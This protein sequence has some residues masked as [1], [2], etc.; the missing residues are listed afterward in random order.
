VA[1]HF[2]ERFGFEVY[3]PRIRRYQTRYRRRIKV[4]RPLFPGYCFTRIELQWHSV[5]QC[6]GVIRIVKGG[7]EEPAHVPDE[8]IDVIRSRERDGALDLP[9]P[10]RPRA[11]R[12]GDRV[13]IVSGLFAGVRAFA[14]TYRTGT[15]AC[16]YSCSARSDRC[17]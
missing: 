4:L 1:Q 2:L 13:Q 9:K 12:I 16:C 10:G 11:P 5:R 6:P 17:S 15:S 14:P 8:I 7:V 3:L